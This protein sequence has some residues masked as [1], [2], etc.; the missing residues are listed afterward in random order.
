MSDLK[1][2]LEPISLFV[3]ELDLSDGPKA[4]AALNERFPAN[5]EE[6]AAIR[7]AGFAALAAGEIA[8]R[9]E[10]GM[11]WGRISK[12]EATPGGC[13]IDVVH[14][15]DSSGPAHTHTNGEVCL[16]FGES[17]TAT[18]ENRGDTWIVMPAGSRHEPTVRDGSM[19]ILYWL[20]EGAV[21]WG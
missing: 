1:S 12:P 7:A 10:P 21:Q 2:L 18:F 4:E 20:P 16:C 9:G 3:P 5:S 17:D 6:I 11:K 8:E 14:M 19:L 13:S 15:C